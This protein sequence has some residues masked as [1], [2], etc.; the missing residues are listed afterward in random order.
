[1]KYDNARLINELEIILKHISYLHSI[2]DK[3][4]EVKESFLSHIDYVFDMLDDVNNTKIVDEII[5][6]EINRIKKRN[7]HL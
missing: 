2:G 1:M 5:S 7:L 3:R 4:S 6:S